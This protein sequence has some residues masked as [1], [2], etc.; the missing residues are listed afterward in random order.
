MIT[1]FKLFE[2]VFDSLFEDKTWD[3]IK[4]NTLK[5]EFKNLTSSDGFPI[6]DEIGEQIILADPTPTKKYHKWLLK[7]FKRLP[8]DQFL[9]Y[10]KDIYPLLDVYNSSVTRIPVEY[11]QYRDLA[12]NNIEDLESIINFII[13]NEYHI[14]KRSQSKLKSQQSK[15]EIHDDFVQV[16]EN[17]DWRIIIPLTHPQSK[18]FAFNTGSDTEE[19]AEWCTAAISSDSA[20]KSYSSV[21]PL[22][23]FHNK[24]D[25]PRRKRERLSH[26]LFINFATRDYD[27]PCEFKDYLNN[28]VSLG[29]FFNKYPGLSNG[30][31][32]FWTNPKHKEY[33]KNSLNNFIN[34]YLPNTDNAKHLQPIA[35]MISASGLI[36][37]GEIQISQENLDRMIFNDLSSLNF[38]SIKKYFDSN[39]EKINNSFSNNGNLTPLFIVINSQSSLVPNEKRDELTMR[40]CKY[41]ISKGADGS[42]TDESGNSN[43]IIESIKNKKFK[44]LM[45]I[46][47]SLDYQIEENNNLPPIS[48]ALTDPS[49][50]SKNGEVPNTLSY[51]EFDSLIQKLVDRGLNLN[52]GDSKHKTARLTGLTVI[53]LRFK[54]FLS[55]N[56]EELIQNAAE[57]IKVFLKYGADPCSSDMRAGMPL[58]TINFFETRKDLDVYSLWNEKSKKCQ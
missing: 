18:Y 30:I 39:P 13:E 52:S 21:A 33:L 32:E 49:T 51:A 22:Y 54:D 57:I 40:I 1:K 12:K 46:I 35:D 45:S 37:S 10:L 17:D 56:N 44:T 3:E 23:I 25:K 5:N 4:Q 58:S 29:N 27:K 53:C 48:Y 14:S 43:I 42:G 9:N 26:Q 50:I 11:S 15:V 6:D 8:K 16:Y 2:S 31:V 47:D 38:S 41:L 19:Y 24:H 34:S 36:E 20:F 28:E 55:K 7:Q